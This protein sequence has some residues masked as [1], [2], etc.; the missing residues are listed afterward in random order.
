MSGIGILIFA[1]LVRRRCTFFAVCSCSSLCV[2]AQRSLWMHSVRYVCMGLCL[3]RNTR[4]LFFLCVYVCASLSFRTG[5]CVRV[6]VRLSIV[7]GT[8]VRVRCWTY[9][10]FVTRLV[11]PYL[12][13]PTVR[14]FARVCECVTL[15]G[16][17]L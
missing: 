3:Y 15:Y 10:V 17:R 16:V 7:E 8:R 12:A 5:S 14:M 11:S 9:V 13:G 6:S 1:A 2:S 4:A